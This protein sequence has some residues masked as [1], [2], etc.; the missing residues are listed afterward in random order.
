MEKEIAQ[1]S[2]LAHPQ[3]LAIFR[4]LMRRYPDRL[5]AG[6][7]AAILGLKPSTLSAYLS[8][9]LDAGLITQERRG[10]SLL[11]APHMDATQTLIGFLLDDCCRARTQPPA[12]GRAPGTIRNVLFL[13]SGNSAR[14]LMAEALLRATAGDRFEVFSAGTEARGAPHPS[15][16]ALLKA[17]GLDT[18][19]LWS[20]PASTFRAADAPPM[21]F[22]I[23]VCDR[24]ANADLD[25]WP[26]RPL[27]AH[28]AVPDPVPAATPQAFADALVRLKQRVDAFAALP[29]DLP[30]PALQA[31]LDTIATLSPGSD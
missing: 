10:T 6:E 20:K 30:R 19:C 5:P 13:C 22:V 25:A 26:N 7:I 2:A 29:A 17:E 8:A 31:A 1:L 27:H 12:P 16:L 24:A 11:Y 9:L 21:D 23:S 28:W 3:R 15:A 18:S 4:L 14:S